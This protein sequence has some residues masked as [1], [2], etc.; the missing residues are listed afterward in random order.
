MAVARQQSVSELRH[1]FGQKPMTFYPLRGVR[2]VVCADLGPH[3]GARPCAAVRWVDED[4]ETVRV[5]TVVSKP[6]AA[7]SKH[8][9]A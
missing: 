5:N 4:D 9:T 8:K 3:V 2:G 1:G 6:T 7:A